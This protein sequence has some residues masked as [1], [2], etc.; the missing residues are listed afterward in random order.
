MTGHYRPFEHE[1]AGSL[2]RLADLVELGEAGMAWEEEEGVFIQGEGV[3]FTFGSWPPTGDY[4][5][6]V[7]PAGWRV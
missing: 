4:N 7:R 2:R 6:L 1:M 5:D 3:N